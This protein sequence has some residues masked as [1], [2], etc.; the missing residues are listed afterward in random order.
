MTNLTA[1]TVL[2]V[3][4]L[5]LSYG[6]ILFLLASGLSLTLGLMRILNLSHGA[7][8]ML[9]AYTGLTVATHAHSYWLGIVA[10]AAAA[11]A[12]GLLLEVGFLRRLYMEQTN[13]VLLT[14]GFIYIITNVVQWIWGTY[15]GAIPVPSLFSSSVIV[16]SYGIE[17]FRLFVIGFGIFMAV[18]L[19]LFQD[20]TK[21][22]AIVRAGMDNREMVSAL[23]IKLKRV[24]TGIF[25][26]GA[27]IAGLCGLIGAPMTGIDLGVSWNALML[28]MIV[29][30]IGGTGSVQG[31]LLGGVLVGLVN[32]FG[33]VYFN[34]Y[35]DY[36]VYIALIVVLL[37]R[38]QG[39]LGRKMVAPQ[40]V[41][42]QKPRRPK[43][44]GQPDSTTAAVSEVPKWGALTF[45]YVP[46]LVAIV[47][48]LVIPPFGGEYFISI[49]TKILIFGIFAMSL[50]L[51]MGN[52]GLVSFGHAVFLAAAGYTV[53]I[54]TTQYF[55]T[56]FWL[57]LGLALA[58]CAGLAAVVGYITLR[59]SGMYF[60]LVTMAIGQLVALVAIK[61]YTRTGGTDGIV[62]ITYP[63]LG[64][65]GEL[66]PI[67]WHILVFMFFALTFV[68]L[69]R[70]V[71]SSF[72]RTL[73]GIRLNEQRMRSLGVNTWRI[74]YVAVIV[75]GVFGGLAGVLFAYNYGN[76]VPAYAALQMSSLP[77]LMVVMGGPGTLWGPC[78]AAGVIIMVQ[79]YVSIW[80]PERWPLVL[81][82]IFVLCVLFLKGGIAPHLDRWW[83]ALRSFVFRSRGS[84]PAAEQVPVA[85]VG[86]EQS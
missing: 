45:K 9:G 28:S 27:A 38:P 68:V 14:I 82:V 63:D 53:G 80:Q 78:I 77:M 54:M 57:N 59:V 52:V 67:T 36:L 84:K 65:G 37:I 34:V 81:G 39:I 10:G 35:A 86:E 76:V 33:I 22:G 69:H 75:G 21:V 8:Y 26:L 42:Q 19:W 16:G 83:T 51:T 71:T 44:T 46:Y 7:L 5:G 85:T 58:L 25:V 43:A 20:R 48:L 2:Y 73:V 17:T 49:M 50:D 47:V 18:L 61:W 30:V 4:V 31:A 13:Q 11:G 60:L 64:F 32:S 74:K 70:V 66:N 23:G 56:S 41:Q 15:P 12:V 6:M 3:F 79:N 62:G 55:H 1:D 40:T 24:F 72:G 29:V